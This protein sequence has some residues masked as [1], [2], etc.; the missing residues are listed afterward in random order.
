MDTGSDLDSPSSKAHPSLHHSTPIEHLM[1]LMVGGFDQ[2]DAVSGASYLTFVS[3]KL[4][5]HSFRYGRIKLPIPR[6]GH[7]TPEH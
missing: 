6:W 7:S 2:V 4:P 3:W 5:T 1:S